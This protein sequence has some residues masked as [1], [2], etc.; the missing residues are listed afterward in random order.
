M[1]PHRRCVPLSVILALA[2]LSAAPLASPF[3]ITSADV[4]QAGSGP[5]APPLSLRDAGGKP[6]RLSD[7]KGR[8]VL[9]DF[10][11]TWCTGCKLEIPWFME[12][13]KKY[14]ANGLSAIGV[15][16]D[17]EGWRTVKIYLAEH[18]ITYPVVLGDMDLMQK[19]FGLPASL[20]VTLLIDR[21]GRVALTHSGVVD[22][23]KFET[24]I[25]QL[26]NEPGQ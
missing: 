8:V 21:K 4:I 3:A 19:K 17:D 2:I 1:S 18:P 13:E 25:R 7:Y 12:F 11:A 16:V 14:R 15:A 20:P 5:S 22:K 6:H 24:D 26:L 23:E 9:L 10:W